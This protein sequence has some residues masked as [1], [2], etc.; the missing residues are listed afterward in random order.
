MV[1]EANGRAEFRGALIGAGFFAH[2]HMQAWRDL[3][4]EGARIEGVCD[5]VAARAQAMAEGFGAQ[6]FTDLVA[7]VDAIRPDCVDI[8]IT[9]SSH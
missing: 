4:P 9:P 3:A 5:L 7:M 8:D 2:N 6:A 1:A